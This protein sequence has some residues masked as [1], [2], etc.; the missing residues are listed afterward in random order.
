MDS[1]RLP[2]RTFLLGATAA[3]LPLAGCSADREAASEDASTPEVYTPDGAVAAEDVEPAD[4][5][6]AELE[7]G[8]V[9]VSYGE[10]LEFEVVVENVGGARGTYE[11]RE[12][13][14]EEVREQHLSM[15]APGDSETF[16]G[17]LDTRYLA[18]GE[19]Y[20][21]YA[22]RNDYAAATV[23]VALEEPDPI[24]LSGWGPEVTDGV[25]LEEGMV[26]AEWR[27]RD[28]R[29]F[30]RSPF[31]SGSGTDG[32]FVATLVDTAGDRLDDRVAEG[33]GDVDG[34][35][36]RGVAG[37][38]YQLDVDAVGGWEIGLRQP[39]VTLKGGEALP[40]ETSGGA[41]GDWF[42]VGTDGVTTVAAEHGGSGAFGVECYTIDGRSH[43]DTVLFDQ[44]GR[45]SGER[46]YHQEWANFVVVQADGPWTLTFESA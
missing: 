29:G 31:G 8:D 4:I 15:L 40:Y 36:G 35:W 32:D 33:S 38:E 10:S 13:V 43:P 42:A 6:L 12:M 27:H 26:V 41:A 18:A 16:S 9:E 21:G 24:E 22:T 19:H 28:T 25:E 3:S 5:R 44:E 39:R 17:R 23:T 1:R 45:F 2:R 37:G 14:G 34:V 20:Y 7:P 46:T 30:L 11:I